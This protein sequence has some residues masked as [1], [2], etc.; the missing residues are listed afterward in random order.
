MDTAIAVV[1]MKSANIIDI[2]MI[3]IIQIYILLVR[4]MVENYCLQ[5]KFNLI[6]YYSPR[7]VGPR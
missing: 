2:I 1:L 3:Y 4:G 5:V 7:P 6:A